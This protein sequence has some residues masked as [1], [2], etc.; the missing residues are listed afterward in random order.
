MKQYLVKLVF[1]IEFDG[2][3]T[4]PQFDEQMRIVEAKS[5]EEAFY[6]A[7]HL[8]IKEQESLIHRTGELIH[9]KFID[10]PEVY[11]LDSFNDGQQICSSTHVTDDESGF[12]Q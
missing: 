9:W 2:H 11:A 12:V 5:T 3:K 8:G 1:K 7:R 6:R 10:V 4:V